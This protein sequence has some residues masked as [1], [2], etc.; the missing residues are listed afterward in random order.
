ME[1]VSGRDYP[2]TY[3]DFVEM[4]PDD[5]TCAAYLARLRWPEG[6]IYT[7]CKI[8]STPWHESR[9]LVFRRLIEQ[10]VITGLIIECSLRWI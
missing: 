9:G 3:R 5:A 2:N 6:F 7:A 1:L 4:F 10:A 8:A